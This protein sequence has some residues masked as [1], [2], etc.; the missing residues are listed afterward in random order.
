MFVAKKPCNFAGKRYAIGE[1]I[2]EG[3]I[4]ESRERTLLKFGTI[5][6][7]EIPEDNDPK[8]NTSKNG[9]NEPNG[10]DMTENGEKPVQESEDGKNGVKTP[11]NTASKPEAKTNS[12]KPVSKNKQKGGK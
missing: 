7:V 1:Q 3:L 6:K 9:E 12:R 5:A 4:D 2:P 8:Q 11:L 10:T